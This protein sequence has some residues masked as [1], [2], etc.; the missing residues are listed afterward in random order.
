VAIAAAITVYLSPPG[1]TSF[2]SGQCWNY[3]YEPTCCGWEQRTDSATATGS[4]V[5]IGAWFVML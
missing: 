5:E 4:D 2:I 1:M 3:G